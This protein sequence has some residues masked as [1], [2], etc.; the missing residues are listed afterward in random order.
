MHYTP[1]NFLMKV[2]V[3][4]KVLEAARSDFAST[5]EQSA[6]VCLC[7]GEN[8][9]QYL[10]TGFLKVRVAQIYIIVTVVTLQICYNLKNYLHIN[11][12]FFSL[13]WRLYVTSGTQGAT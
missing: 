3:K 11:N 10:F 5:L 9:Q 1:L 13:T 7:P 2:H 6:C 4:R 8:L 12:I